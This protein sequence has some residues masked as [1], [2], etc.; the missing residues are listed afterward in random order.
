M[1]SGPNDDCAV[2]TASFEE[3]DLSTK[4]N[5][6]VHRGSPVD[7][8][9]WEGHGLMS[10]ILDDTSQHE[11]YATGKV[12]PPSGAYENTVEV[13]LQLQPTIKLSKSAFYDNLSRESKPTVNSPPSN[14]RLTAPIPIHPQSGYNDQRKRSDDQNLVRRYYEHR[15]QPPMSLPSL[16]QSVP[17]Y[18]HESHHPSSQQEQKMARMERNQRIQNDHPPYRHRISPPT[19][20]QTRPASQPAR[21]RYPYP[22]YQGEGSAQYDRL[23]WRDEG[24][25]LR[26]TDSQQQPPPYTNPSKDIPAYE[27][28]HPMPPSGPPRSPSTASA[29]SDRSST[30]YHHHDQPHMDNNNAIKHPRLIR[31]STAA[32]ASESNM[33]P[34]RLPLGKTIHHTRRKKRDTKP[35]NANELRTIVELEKDDHGN[36]KLPVEVDSWTVISL[37]KVIWDKPAFHNQRYIYPV[38]YVVKKWYRSMID[39][40]RDT[41]YICSILDGG[42][43]PLTNIALQFRLQADDNPKEVFQGQTPTSVWTIAV[44]RAFAVRNMEY[45]HNPVGPDFFGLRKNTIAKMIQDLPNA[46]KCRNYVWQMFEI[47]RSKQGRGT[48]RPQA[49]L[50]D[51]VIHQHQFEQ[52]VARGPIGRIRSVK[53]NSSTGDSTLYPMRNDTNNQ[54]DDEDD[55]EDEMDE[56]E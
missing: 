17:P 47:G 56:D 52:S 10:W 9:I 50:A 29:T 21:D 40:H 24:P 37:G 33:Y 22:S 15:E 41:Q 26:I 4:Y 32:P 2:Y 23:A 6:S 5:N 20:Y 28:R 39:P 55:E 36:Y 13:I 27:A 7:K 51:D 11:L 53:L 8:V 1:L 43:E 3:S 34:Y 49:T 25:W 44:R 18:H 16:T 31:A 14:P 19:T 30:E 48:K 54:Q 35:P 42:N 12:G 46:D 45:G 38:G